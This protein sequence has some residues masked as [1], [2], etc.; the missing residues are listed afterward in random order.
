MKKIV[1]NSQ[2]KNEHTQNGAS[3]YLKF[4]KDIS[5]VKQNLQE[6]MKNLIQAKILNAKKKKGVIHMLIKS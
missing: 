1:K 3:N 5:Q 4:S 6:K 2:F